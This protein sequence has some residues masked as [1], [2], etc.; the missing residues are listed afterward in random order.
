MEKKP[1]E[2]KEWR[3]WQ[4]YMI[5]AIL[6]VIALFFLPMIGT[7]AGLAFVVPTTAIG[8]VVYIVSKL[9]VATL[10]IM[11]FHCFIQQGRVNI[12]KD[13]AYLEA[14]VILEECLLEKEHAPR[15]PLQWTR[16]TYGKKGV[17]IFVTTIISVIGLTQ[18]VLTFDVVSMLTYLF[19][20]IMGIIFGILQMNETEKYWTEEFLDYAKM[21]QKNKA[22][23][24]NRR[25]LEVVE[26]THTEPQDDTTSDNGGAPILESPDSDGNT[27][28]L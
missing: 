5:I 11:I 21:V 4:Y 22:E 13:P 10:N 23:E 12:A 2:L 18:A 9:L 20:V 25:S 14:K 19:T 17:T 1:F 3:Q 6:S 28:L 26:E 8:W 7:Q 16:S 27:S 15:S 24:A